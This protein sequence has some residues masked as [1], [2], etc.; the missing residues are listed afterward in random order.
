MHRVS[1]TCTPYLYCLALAVKVGD[2]GLEV[3]PEVAV[4]VGPVGEWEGGRLDENAGGRALLMGNT[5]EDGRV[6]EVQGIPSH[7]EAL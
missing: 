1:P 3:K 7:F 6:G 2:G 4:V 5:G